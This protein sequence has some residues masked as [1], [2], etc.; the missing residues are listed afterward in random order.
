MLS[1]CNLYRCTQS[2]GDSDG[3]IANLE[4]FLEIAK[5]G[6]YTST[7]VDPPPPAVEVPLAVVEEV[8]TLPKEEAS[9]LEVVV[10][11][12]GFIPCTLNVIS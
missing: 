3:A 11:A 6:L 5:V 2:Q 1:K 8:D 9:P 4:A 7:S 12:P 10:I